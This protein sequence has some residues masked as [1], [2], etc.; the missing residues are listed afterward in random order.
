MSNWALTL[1]SSPE[2]HSSRNN[3]HPLPL[4]LSGHLSIWKWVTPAP[5]FVSLPS[6]SLSLSPCSFILHHSDDIAVMSKLLAGLSLAP[7]R[8]STSTGPCQ[9]KDVTCDDNN[10]VTS[11]SLVS[12]SLLRTLPSNLGSLTQLTSL[13]L[14]GNSFSGPL[15]SLAN[16]SSLHI[17]YLDNNNFSSI[18]D[19]FF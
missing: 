18:P 19:G 6:L 3:S 2:L 5:F 10:R 14:Q 12:K 8:W 17:L 13:F 9:W 7:S 16:L 4:P 11:I 1:V 15:P